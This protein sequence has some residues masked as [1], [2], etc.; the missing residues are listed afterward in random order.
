MGD[1]RWTFDGGCIIKTNGYFGVSDRWVFIVLKE[2][3]QLYPDILEAR[4][5]PL[6]CSQATVYVFL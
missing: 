1:Q 4:V 5:G 3:T 6:Q 2:L